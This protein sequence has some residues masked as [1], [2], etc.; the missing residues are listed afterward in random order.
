M[1]T[2]KFIL[3]ACCGGKM[4]WIN[5]NQPNTIYIDI[6]KENAGFIKQRPKQEIK[7][8]VIMDFRDMTFQDKSFKLVV[9]E[10]PHLKTLG[11]TS[12]FRKKFGSLNAMTWQADLKA[13]FN[14]CWRVLEDYGILIFKWSDNEISFKDV[15]DL[16]PSKPLFQNISNYKSTSSSCWFCFMKIPEVSE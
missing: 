12:L 1:I 7:P 5:K 6:R 10:P 16:A 13:G 15:L 8:D 2:E 14:E 11:E 9:F 3:D 4:M